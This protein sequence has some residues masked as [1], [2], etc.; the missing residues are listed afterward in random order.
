MRTAEINLGSRLNSVISLCGRLWK[1]D[2]PTEDASCS[3]SVTHS[4]HARDAA[5]Y[6]YLYGR[7]GPGHIPYH[8]RLTGSVAGDALRASTGRSLSAVPK[9]GYAHNYG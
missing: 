4:Y 6:G 9:S 1:L 3:K 8:M 2:G 5:L 7:T